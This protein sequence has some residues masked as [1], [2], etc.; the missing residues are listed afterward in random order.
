MAKR[1]IIEK[2][3]L[4]QKISIT[5]GGGSLLV[6]VIGFGMKL[7]ESR[8]K[9][10]VMPEHLT[11]EFLVPQ[12]SGGGGQQTVP[13]QMVRA[14]AA[15]QKILIR[16][17]AKPKGSWL[18]LGIDANGRVTDVMQQGG[19][20]ETRLMEE[21]G[22]LVWWVDANSAVQSVLLVDVP[23]TFQQPK[24]QELRAAINTIEAK[25]TVSPGI[26]L[27]FSEAGVTRVATGPEG[28][29]EVQP[30]SPTDTKW[31]DQLA[32]VLNRYDLDYAGRTFA[33]KAAATQPA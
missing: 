33:V 27:A 2:L 22:A 11:V 6:A 28:K 24:V 30:A 26:Q 7:S 17:G 15:M 31:A 16:P 1:Q 13:F 21:D 12:A 20:A 29:G 3:T 4:A 18:V 5:I 32:D 19:P 23:A 14:L 25:P 10:P 8:A 9:G